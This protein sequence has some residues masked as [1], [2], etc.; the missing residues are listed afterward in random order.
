MNKKIV[1]ILLAIVLTLSFS[2][3]LV[4]CHSAVNIDH[5]EIYSM[6]KTDYLVGES[7]DITDA[8]ILVVYKNNTE[9]LVDITPSMLS[10]FNSSTLGTQY[11]N[12]Y[13]E[14]HSAVFAVNV[15][16][17]PVST[18]ELIVPASNVNYVQDQL[19]RTDGT[20]MQINFQ[21]GSYERIAVTK[22]M[23]SGFDSNDIGSQTITVRATLDGV[24]YTG[25]FGVTVEAKELIAIEV[26]TAPTKN[27]YYI[28]DDVIDL[29]GGVLLFKYNSGYSTYVDMTDV[30]GNPINGLSIEWDT[31]VV[32]NNSNV[33]VKYQH[34]TSNFQVQ[35]KIRDVA[36]YEIL[37][38]P[39]TQKQNL[40]LDLTGTVIKLN[41]NNGESETV[42]LPSDKVEIQN[43]DKSLVGKQTVALVFKY[44]EGVLAT[45]GT[46]DIEV[47]ERKPVEDNP[48]EL[49]DCVIYQDTEFDVS[50]VKVRIV[51][52]NGEYGDPVAL[53]NAMIEWPNGI[54]VNVYSEAGKKSWRISYMG[55]TADCDFIV[56]ALRVTNI[57]LFNVSNV[58]AYTGD[59]A[60]AHVGDA[61]MTITYNSGLVKE[62]VALDP[63]MLTFDATT[64]GVK[65]ATLT[66]TDKYEPGFV[67]AD[68]LNV[69]VVK[70]ISS[71]VIGGSY[72][73]E[74]VIGEKF[75][76]TGMILE[77]NYEGAGEAEFVN[78]NDFGTFW[79]F[80]S[81]LA[82]GSLTFNKVGT[83]R[84]YL[85]NLGINEGDEFSFTV[86]VTND[87]VS[88]ALYKIDELGNYVET[89]SLGTVVQGL[90]IDLTN[91]RILATYQGSYE[92]VQVTSDML[93]YNF[94]DN[95]LGQRTVVV[96]YEGLALA[97]ATDPITVNV[98]ARN[99]KGIKVIKSPDKTIYVQESASSVL[100]YEGLKLNLVYDNE[101]TTPIDV[102]QSVDD[103]TLSFAGLDINKIGTQTI[104]VTYIYGE[105]SYQDTFEIE[106]LSPE[107][108]S[109]SW[110]DGVVPESYL[111]I[112]AAFNLKTISYV[113]SQGYLERLADKKINVENSNGII[114][115]DISLDTLIDNFTVT[116]YTATQT[117]L[118]TVHLKY[119]SSD[120]Y[121]AV[122]VHVEER[123]L[124]K[125]NLLINGA[126]KLTI[127]QGAP[128]DLAN[129]KLELVFNDDATSVVPM[130]A[131]YINV[132]EA[133]PNGY[134][135]TNT[136]IG[137]R[138]VTISYTYA[139][140]TT[141]V[142][143]TLALE[144]YQKSLTEIVINDI[145]KQYYVEGESYDKSQGSIMLY[146]NN[147]TTMVVPL[148]E[149][150]IGNENSSFNIDIRRFNNEEF[151]GFSKAQRIEIKYG[152]CKT[153]YTIYMRDRRNAFVELGQDNQ[154][155]IVYGT[156]TKHV[157]KLMGY[158][159]A[160]TAEEDV[161]EFNKG[162]F[163]VEYIPQEVW[164][165]VGREF[166][167]D[168]T[169]F[170][171]KVGVYYIVVSYAGD[172]QHNAYE[173]AV[174]TLT[175]NKKTLYVTIANATMIYGCQIPEIKIMLSADGVNFENDP[176]RLFVEGDNFTSPNFNPEVISGTVAYLVNAKGEYVL[177]VNGDK[178]VIDI[179][180]IVYKMGNSVVDVFS[181]SKAGSY[182]IDVQNKFVSP[183]YDIQYKY[184]ALTINPR[185]VLVTPQDLSYTYG[186]AVVPVIPFTVSAVS[187]EEDTTGL[188]PTDVLGGALSRENSD[189]KTVGD[190][191]VTIGSLHEFNKEYYQIDLVG[192]AYVRIIK[193]IVYVKTD[194]VIK[195]YGE[196]F[197]TPA[198]KFYSDAT[199][200]IEYNAFA[201]GD[202]VELDGGILD[203]SKVGSVDI[204]NIAYNETTPAG[205]YDD[206]AADFVLTEFGAAN[207][208]VVLVAGV[209]EVSKRPVSVVADT[210]TVAYGES[211]KLTYKARAIEGDSASGLLASD[212]QADGTAN[213]G[214]F[215]GALDRVN[216]TNVGEYTILIGDLASSN[217]AISF[218]SAKYV[219]TPK[220][221]YVKIADTDLTKVYDG[222]KPVVNAYALYEDS[223]A[224]KAYDEE[225]AVIA[226]NFVIITIE[227]AT[228]DVNTYGITVSASS[229]NYAVQTITNYSYTIT[230]RMVAL[231]AD[232]Y[233]GIPYDL[234]YKGEAYSF[235]AKVPKE[236]LQ[237]QYNDDGSVKT[238]DNNAPLYDDDSVTLST[239]S[240]VNAG[241]YTITAVR[242]NNDN[243]Q[244]D[245]DNSPAITFELSPYTLKVVIKNCNENNVFEREYNNQM[246]YLQTSEYE[247]ENP[248]EGY[249]MPQYSLGIF[250]NGTAANY[251]DVLFDE[252]SG[253]VIGYDILVA[254]N[255]SDTNYNV[256]LK[257]AYT[258]KIV[259][260]KVSIS[261]YD[262]YKSKTYDGKEPS[263]ANGTFTTTEAVI[264]F[265]SSKVSFSF[266]RTVQ[267]GRPNSTVGFYAV[268]VDCSDRNFKVVLAEPV[269]YEIKQANLSATLIN[270]EKAYNA[271]AFRVLLE[272]LE[273][274]SLY[275]DN[276][277]NFYGG[278]DA[279]SEFGKFKAAMSAL[280]SAISNVTTTAKA[281][282]FNNEDYAL[283]CI[284]N[285]R[286]AL[287]KLYNQA[288]NTGAIKAL[289]AICNEWGTNKHS[290]ANLLDTYFNLIIDLVNTLNATYDTMEANLSSEQ[291]SQEALNTALTHIASIQN[292]FDK[293]NTYVAFVFAEE[294]I[295]AGDEG[296]EYELYYSDINRVIGITNN[297]KKVYIATFDY[298]IFPVAS[299]SEFGDEFMLN[300]VIRDGESSNSNIIDANTLDKIKSYYDITITL[301]EYD[302][303]NPEINAVKSYPFSIT[304]K[305]I[306]DGLPCPYSLQIRYQYSGEET[307]MHKI[308]RKK[309]TY[310][311]TIE[312]EGIY[313]DMFSLEGTQ[314]EIGQTS[315]DLLAYFDVD[316]DNKNNLRNSNLRF[317]LDSNDDG[318]SDTDV[319]KNYRFSKVGSYKIILV[320]QES[321]KYDISVNVDGWLNVNKK[322]L[323]IV[324][325]SFNKTYGLMYAEETYV[326]EDLK[327]KDGH[328]FINFIYNGIVEE[329]DGGTEISVKNA[330]LNK[331][332]KLSE[333]QWGYEAIGVDPFASTTT[334]AE[335]IGGLI[336]YLKDCGYE[337]ENYE[338][339]FDSTPITVQ[340]ER[341]LLSLTIVSAT[342]RALSSYYMNTPSE[343]DYQIVYEGFKNN[344]KENEVE[345][346]GD[347]TI[348]VDFTNNGAYYDAGSRPINVTINGDTRHEIDNYI[349][350]ASANNKY[351]VLPRIIKAWLENVDAVMADLTGK[352]KI[353]PYRV[354]MDD[355]SNK[356]IVAGQYGINNFKFEVDL[357]DV[358]DSNRRK[359]IEDYF[360]SVTIATGYD[361][362]SLSLGD[363]HETNALYKH[364]IAYDSIDASNN[365]ALARL[366][367][368]T[369][370]GNNF[371]INP[372]GVDASFEIKVYP[373]IAKFEVVKAVDRL[374]AEDLVKDGQYPKGLHKFIVNLIYAGDA[375]IEN[376]EEGLSLLDCINGNYVS[377][378]GAIPTVVN[379][380]A[381]VIANINAN[382]AFFTRTLITEASSQRAV[383]AIKG[384]NP[385]NVTDNRTKVYVPEVQGSEILLRFYNDSTAET[386]NP[387]IGMV[388][389]ANVEYRKIVANGGTY[390]TV[391]EH[392]YNAMHLE[393][394][395]KPTSSV[396]NPWLEVYLSG[397]SSTSPYIKLK[398]THGAPDSLTIMTKILAGDESPILTRTLTDIKVGNLFDGLTHDIRTYLDK[399]TLD[400]IVTVDGNICA[401]VALS[402]LKDDNYGGVYS[403]LISDASTLIQSSKFEI[404]VSGDFSI[405]YLKLSEQGLFEA[406]GSHIKLP[407]LS[408][409]LTVNDG[410]SY[411]LDKTQFNNLMGLYL[412]DTATLT[413]VYYVNGRPVFGD[414]QTTI[415]LPM[416]I[417]LIELALYDGSTLVDYQ[418][419]IVYVI[420]NKE[421]DYFK[422]TFVIRGKEEGQAYEYT[423]DLLSDEDG[424]TYA[425]LSFVGASGMSRV[426][427][428]G[429]SIL[430]DVSSTLVDS[431]EVV[432]MREATQYVLIIKN[433]YT[434]KIAIEK[435]IGDSSLAINGTFASSETATL[436]ILDTT[437]EQTEEVYKDYN[438]DGTFTGYGS[439]ALK[440]GST[441]TFVGDEYL[442]YDRLT[443]HFN[444][445]SA[446]GKI[447][448]NLF[449]NIDGDGAYIEYD[450]VSNQISFIYYV[451]IQ[452]VGE[453]T[454]V[455][456]SEEQTLSLETAN[457]GNHVIDVVINKEEKSVSIVVD[458][459]ANAVFNIYPVTIG[460]N[461]KEL[462]MSAYNKASVVTEGQKITVNAFSVY[463]NENNA[464]VD[465]AITEESQI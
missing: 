283:N 259:P 238:D 265:N 439:T 151:T 66:Y 322:K 67:K 357:S 446:D 432:L 186:T 234:E 445:E 342:D 6:P 412:A 372:M 387:E 219:I 125:I 114:N 75:D 21:D 86:N 385:V 189:V 277:L 154:Y 10:D 39:K 129:L 182:S 41:Y 105:T 187:G 200:T 417:H 458:E 68:A 420:E 99:V 333:I 337:M 25:S 443:I 90:P 63:E 324:N 47:E 35:V 158:D 264:G 34:L 266:E 286:E 353:E 404:A 28:Y 17:Y 163:T 402:S 407:A 294:P 454:M 244:I 228:K 311:I 95:S 164:L 144:V 5:I 281:I 11:I 162:S 160:F 181:T 290:N 340:V 320:G 120:L 170:P 126:D 22:D 240:V 391:S 142:T 293:A 447:R 380:S 397:N 408:N 318:I 201:E 224:E 278:A 335:S 97:D 314:L 245:V 74:Y 349:I 218:V 348:D 214:V 172:S 131:S 26:T 313:G 248:L 449:E 149:A 304:P 213:D 7:L 18:V 202:V 291:Y 365:T 190:Y 368:M 429:N 312:L 334:V 106:V 261:I 8:K 227:N 428:N 437:F 102:T 57:E 431:Y 453:M 424:N 258:Y 459:V 107:P 463:S 222:K 203:V 193:R 88:L 215:T 48:F 76:T 427:F 184:G 260:K 30:N 148:A 416:G 119:G 14:N 246:A 288:D 241:T 364:A 194:S 256:V 362:F 59:N 422:T 438:V 60:L 44:G 330:E 307:I 139:N 23:C 460:L 371:A 279:S 464:Y 55:L 50:D 31:S 150:T 339:D 168:Y 223:T 43:Y 205:T 326:A 33:T 249:E 285:A 113:G 331:T 92:Y 124:K 212:M 71:V 444:N 165:D 3:V 24:E 171:S 72:K 355:N 316:A 109:I 300:Y 89:N 455:K 253:E 298:Y 257:E 415:E 152:A 185:K 209:L 198:V 418:D 195:V 251:S 221:L 101:T 104:T 173:Q 130:D 79:T 116:G 328:Q 276:V 56:E 414:D 122:R 410:E 436:S 252:N 174:Q 29:R 210:V 70:E 287:N 457:V 361:G 398:F 295:M 378:L 103:A 381:S 128:I 1:L 393:I 323:T 111:T 197:T 345:I 413:T 366:T 19:L 211:G 347:L 325:T 461:T 37:N 301:R 133:N 359:E 69:T 321:T 235:Y 423:T 217:Y 46:M 178:I 169:V 143:L 230:P 352:V 141:P 374:L 207:Y 262:G 306:D 343:A 375:W 247:I 425:T 232:D 419:R 442:S 80:R 83:V 117:G 176:M 271:S 85:V 441:L 175:I 156:T 344:D 204:S 462:V 315:I 146:Y 153:S 49:V 456:G 308:V 84:I 346:L 452:G 317:G 405:R 110:S 383:E 206:M 157:I 392:E 382:N 51:F 448:I 363:V 138:N 267:D 450:L 370:A 45:G 27:I 434:G 208:K 78:A 9:Q 269:D 191:K 15:S 239:S 390:R 377:I 305:L 273:F 367:G 289:T 465:K 98:V 179:F 42:T 53:N 199:C 112:G 369:V 421:S 73:T 77:V 319:I 140:E 396:L 356:T 177:D 4:S 280:S 16:R 303:V 399:E 134:D 108:K 36:S 225:L 388:G 236:A 237:L 341:A 220:A 354:T 58:F 229:N 81:D 54:A 332:G 93:D 270:I 433:V 406:T 38:N 65:K 395:I 155:S 309:L 64:T 118:Q 284:S 242:I 159:K 32:S 310:D 167:V 327:A 302:F 135:V 435:N 440:E 136:D 82:D 233:F 451:M 394:A 373:Q 166:G 400:L 137:T 358:E 338:I 127:I 226:K 292:T 52:D 297:P 62:N 91:Y 100:S 360:N 183:N 12:V 61:N 329:L 123:V 188:L 147:G 350:E 403:G 272:D 384:S 250:L 351:T 376:N 274:R 411:A 254:V 299:E 243:Y 94:K 13:Y 268:S 282:R 275:I 386:V 426:Y 20:Y 401:N 2:M 216:G 96:T 192:E 409:K 121:L 379:K 263:L 115:N 196:P 231:D 145:P 296:Y 87:L 40:D 255:S 336:V 132:S 389:G 161:K 180:N 430:E